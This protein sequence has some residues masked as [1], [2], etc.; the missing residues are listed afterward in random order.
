MRLGDVFSNGRYRSIH[1]LGWGGYS[2]TWL[3]RDIVG[4]RNVAL[5]IST[6]ESTGTQ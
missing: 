4:N 5:K 6:A 2:T 3:A 1:K